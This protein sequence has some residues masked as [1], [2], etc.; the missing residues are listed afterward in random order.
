MSTSNVINPK[1]IKHGLGMFQV[2]KT[3]AGKGRTFE[4]LKRSPAVRLT[5]K[6]LEETAKIDG[7]PVNVDI[8]NNRFANEAIRLA[9]Q[10]GNKLVTVLL[11]Q[12][13]LKTVGLTATIHG[14][15]PAVIDLEPLCL[16]YLGPCKDMEAKLIQPE[17]H[18]YI[19]PEDIAS[20]ENFDMGD[21]LEASLKANDTKDKILVT[22][23]AVFA[24]SSSTTVKREPFP[25]ME[26]PTEVKGLILQGKDSGKKLEIRAKEPF[27]GTL[28]VVLPLIT[29]HDCIELAPLNIEYK[30]R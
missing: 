25:E 17:V 18:H 20:F 12:S 14:S 11:R 21:A 13:L 8:I 2:F 10:G 3:L 16:L 29:A 1:S 22:A 19:K 26:K 6:E 23:P 7:K 24:D 28:S 5:R 27:S 30:K 9:T 15:K 4:S